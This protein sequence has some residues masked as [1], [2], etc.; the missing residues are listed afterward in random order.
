MG[1]MLMKICRKVTFGAAV[2][3]LPLFFLPFPPPVHGL[4][5]MTPC[6][7][8]SHALLPVPLHR[9]LR[10]IRESFQMYGIWSHRHASDSKEC[11]LT[12]WRTKM[13]R[14]DLRAS[15]SALHLYVWKCISCIAS[16]IVHSDCGRTETA[17][18]LLVFHSSPCG[19]PSLHGPTRLPT[20]QMGLDAVSQRAPTRLFSRQRVHPS[21]HQSIQRPKHGRRQPRPTGR[22]CVHRLLEEA[23]SKQGSVCN[24]KVE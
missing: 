12:D 24:L 6:I 8:C 10:E 17:C 13:T 9:R 7:I 19:S 4:D 1:K 21:I 18:T 3:F 14:V 2:V 5:G 11:W 15:H 23:T 20:E 22:G 16:C